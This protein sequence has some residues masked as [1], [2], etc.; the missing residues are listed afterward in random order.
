MK[1]GRNAIVS[2]RPANKVCRKLCALQAEE[3]WL[4]RE[5]A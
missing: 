2:L 1:N 4:T 3:A 5:D